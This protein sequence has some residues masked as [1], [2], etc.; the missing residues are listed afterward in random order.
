M[1]MMS[2]DLTSF[3]FWSV[4]W[5]A[6]AMSPALGMAAMAEAPTKSEKAVN[7]DFNIFMCGIVMDKAGIH[8][9]ILNSEEARKM[10]EN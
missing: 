5:K 2:E 4:P 10:F 1:P 8:N 7:K 6:G 9:L 3:P